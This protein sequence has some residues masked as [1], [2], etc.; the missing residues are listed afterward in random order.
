MPTS[1][2]QPKQTSQIGTLSESSL[3]A[4]L[5]DYFSE[6]GDSQE[7]EIEGYYIDICRGQQLIEIQTRHFAALK[8]KLQTLSPSYTINVVHPIAQE[9][10]IVRQESNGEIVSRRKSPKGGR[11]EDLFSELIRYPNMISTP[12]VS[13]TIALIQADEIWLNDGKG[14]WRRRKWSIADRKLLKVHK[15]ILFQSSVDLLKLLP[16]TLPEE[17]TNRQLSQALGIRARLAQKMTYCFRKLDL[18][19]TCGK[20]GKANLHRITTTTQ[21]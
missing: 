2:K 15:T 4:D 3:H 12:N 11:V 16:R 6:P 9:K 5:K 21:A 18:V 10:W 1:P 17:F 8:T 19:E 13:L 7:V 14:S 20:Q